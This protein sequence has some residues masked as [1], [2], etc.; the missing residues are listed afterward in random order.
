MHRAGGINADKF[1][2]DFLPFPRLLLPKD[3]PS[4][5]IRS[6]WLFSHLLRSVKL[7]N[8]GGATTALSISSAAGSKATSSLA[9]TMGLARAVLASFNGKLEA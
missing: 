9:I 1:N 7:I 6:T 2:L 8:P 4:C 3:S 5:R